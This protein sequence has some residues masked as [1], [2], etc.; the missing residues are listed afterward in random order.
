MPRNKTSATNR[1]RVLIEGN[2]GYRLHHSVML[3]SSTRS[4]ARPPDALT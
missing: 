3:G 4:T 2:D 1:R